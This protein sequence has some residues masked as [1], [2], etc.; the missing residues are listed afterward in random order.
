M[1]IFQKLYEIEN[2]TGGDV[3]GIKKLIDSG[4]VT[5]ASSMPSPDPKDS[6][7]EIELFNRFNRDYPNYADG[8]MLVKPSVDGSRPG[9]SG[10]RKKLEDNIQ[11]RDNTYE[12]EVKRGDTFYRKSFN[13]KNYNS[14][15]EALEAARNFRDEKKKIPYK[16]GIQNPQIVASSPEEYREKY[17]ELKGLKDP[18]GRRKLKKERETKIKNF[19]G[20]KKKIKATGLRDFML[21]EVGYK[22][23]DAADVRKLFPNLEIEQDNLKLSAE[24]K[25]G[26]VR[27]NKNQLN[28]ANRYANLLN[29]RDPNDQYYVSAKK[30]EELPEGER[31][32]ITQIMKNNKGKFNKNFSS[33]LRF[34]SK[35]EK[36]IMDNFNLTEDD[37]IKH[38]KTGVPKNIDGKLNPKYTAI[39]TFIKNNFKFKKIPKTS[40]VSLDQQE[41]IK[42][43]FELPE[44]Q[45]WNFRSQ[46]NPNGF[47]YG[48]SSSTRTGDTGNLAKR[49]ENRMKDQRLS[50]TVASDTSTP[51]GWMM[52][53]MNRLYEQEIKNKVKY[54]NLTYQPIKNKK[55]IIIGFKD[56]TASGNGGTYYGLK[57]NTPEDA[58]A[59]TAHGDYERINKF[60][61]IA[62]GA[63][64]DDPG[65]LLQKIL[66]DKGITKLMGDKS[67]LTLN[68][69]LSHQRYFDKL[70]T[71]APK[72]LIERQIVLHHTKR[73][74]GD[75][76]KAA[77]TKDIQLLTG[78]VNQNVRKL[79]TK[80]KKRKLTNQEIL[81]LKNYG[82][83][84]TDFD[85]KVVG[86][87]S[88]VAEK[89][90]AN[91][92][93]G[94]IEYAKSDKFNLKTV[95]SYLE[96][97]GCG[98][99]AGGRVYFNEGA[100]GLTK[101]AEKGQL[102]LENI[103]K[104]GAVAGS[105]D[106]ILARQI[107][108]IGGSLK[109]SFTLRGMFGP[110]A[111]A[112][113]VGTEAGFVGYDML[114]K[115]N[116]MREAI[117][118]S[119]F[120][121]MLG[122]KT[123]IDPQEELFKRYR[124]LGYDDNQ[125]FRLME[126]IRTTNLINRGKDIDQRAKA[127]A[128]YVQRLRSEPDQF[129]SPDDQMMSDTRSEM[130]EQKLKDIEQEAIDYNKFLEQ[131][132]RPGGMTK[133][134]AIA[135]Y[136]RS[137]EYAK[138]LELVDEADAA[139]TVQRM[140][141]EG[142]TSVG[143]FSPKFEEYRQRTI[144][145]NLPGGGVNPAARL[146]IQAYEDPSSLPDNFQII[147]L[148]PYGLKKGGR[149]GY[150]S[151]KLV[152][153]VEIDFASAEDKA[154]SDMMKAFRYYIKSGG[155][156]SLR[157]Y[158]R[159]A[160][161]RKRIG[162]GKEHFRGAGG[163]IAKLA[164]IDDGP[165]PKSGPNPQGLQGLLKRVKKI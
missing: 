40:M 96:R 125:M 2:E 153:P 81:D 49:I 61:D 26:S 16:V 98:K 8:G 30:Y 35:K 109:D 107:L 45:E 59:W 129:M 134:D 93:K 29:K 68:D 131:V 58:T 94:A 78:V 105:G 164:G 89:Q 74:G 112:F 95:A 48:V 43:N 154:F 79:E 38:G 159:T 86:G 54:E 1:D 27:L 47:K 46:D 88:L 100:M 130:A 104:K 76:A 64:V 6:V 99:A 162:G 108:K 42:N 69:I 110:A 151:G 132:D 91:I 143:V 3:S 44:G 158:M 65:K 141:S 152:E 41:F 60:L 80:A 20:N 57:K 150:N 55:G 92:E 25:K 9:Y 73:I 39:N 90:F 121:Y 24:K 82:A 36:L 127:Q 123:K 101:C 165:P 77:A 147:P 14:K 33:R 142:P 146:G 128:K 52:R 18:T 12:V 161:G 137:G 5:I 22:N 135:Q 126:T 23:Y 145:E 156:K 28:I 34:D 120:N 15:E 111:M 10:N 149:A 113:L 11:V 157:D 84:I 83:R 140:Q 37:F 117:G 21:N 17:R 163:G 122:E 53:S 32:K 85:G 102:K 13:A 118:N 72:A 31:A 133:E 160:V 106:E 62:K 139:A 155:T 7:R 119:L 19:I 4:Q 138:G 148:Q 56:N 63:Q 67:V 50:Y 136:F 75:L 115:G 114:T 66:D 97:L 87:G 116:T 71:T 124:S 51:Q 103:V 144:A 70:S